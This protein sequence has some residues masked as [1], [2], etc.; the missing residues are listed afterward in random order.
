MGKG[1]IDKGSK[2]TWTMYPRRLQAI[3]DEIAKSQK[4]EAGDPRMIA[5]GRAQNTVPIAQYEALAHKPEW[6]DPR[7]YILSAN[8]PD[9]LTATKFVNTLIKN[10]VTIH[11]ATAPFSAGGK[12]YPAG[13]WVVKTAQAFRPHVLDMFEPQDHPNDFQFPGGPPIPPY[14]NAGWTLAYQMGVKFDRILDGFTGPFERVPAVRA[15][16]GRIGGPG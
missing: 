6:R 3:K 5:G 14:D 16:A 11:R 8:Q 12:Q 2:D 7:G 10:G 9:F 15:P 4:V 1:S 13:S